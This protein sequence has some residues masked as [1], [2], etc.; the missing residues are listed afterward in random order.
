MDDPIALAALLRHFDRA[1]LIDLGAAP[2]AVDALLASGD[3]VPA[4]PG[5]LGYQLRE[6][7][8]AAALEQLRAGSGEAEIELHTRIFD[9]FLRRIQANDDAEAACLYHLDRLFFLLNPRGAWDTIARHTAAVRAAGPRQPQHHYQ[10]ALYEGLLALRS[11]RYDAALAILQPLVQQQDLPGQLRVRVHNSIGQVYWFQA[12][13]DRALAHYQQVHDLARA[14]GLLYYQ[15]VALLNMSQ[16]YSDLDD[17]QRA[18]E[19]LRQSLPIF[20][21][22]RDDLRAAHVHYEIGKNATLLGAWRLAQDHLGEAGRLY[23]RLGIED[24]TLDLAWIEGLLYHLT[25]D[26]TRSEAAY[27]RALTAPESIR[28]VYP[29][30]E[31]D[32]WLYLGFLYQVQARWDEAHAAY[33]QAAARAHQTGRELSLALIHY[34]R[35]NVYER[36]GRTEDALSAYSA[37]I[38]GIEALRGATETEEV[39]IGLLGTAQQVY[40]SM[41]LLLLRQGRWEDAFHYVERARSRAFLDMLARRDPELSAR[42]DAPVATL[43]EV[44]AALPEGALLLEYFT[45]GVLPRGEHL[46]NRIPEANARLR[47]HLALPPQTWIF[48]VTRE[49]LEVQRAPLDPNTLRPQPGDPGPGRRLLRERLLTTLYERLVAPAGHLLPGRDLLYLVPHGPLHYVPFM[50]LRAPSGAPLLEAGGPAIALAPS[51][52]VL[53][54]C[55]A[56]PARGAGLSLALGYDD[57]GLAALRYAEAE[58]G[59]IARLT[60]GAAWTGAAPK[61]QRLV[62]EGVR[63][64]RLHIAGHAIY[65]PHD[66]LGSEVRLGRG[67]SLTARAIIGGLRLSAELVT[68]SACTSGL[69]HVVPGDELLGLQRAFLFAGAPAVVCTLWEAADLVA[70]L[71]MDRFYRAVLSGAAPAAALRDA[72]VAVRGMTGRDLAETLERWRR[73]DPALSAALGELPAVPP[74]HLETRLYA[75]PYYWAPFM[76]IGRPD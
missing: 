14:A 24:R 32:V 58:A 9:Y 51:A 57:E 5:G 56:R 70:L 44:Q 25:G 65:H 63:L 6:E 64:R 38:A 41:V 15:G 74:E 59:H 2:E 47:E 33:E 54:M 31:M 16:V 23:H 62:E 28:S 55:L 76:L 49:G 20:Q 36:Q 26:E 1:L 13:Y 18:L 72:Q 50:A 17:P 73:E 21:A 61:S 22:L 3:A 34:R 10:L 37:A 27:R 19:L 45:T 7:R 35:G 48:A 39:K 40:E 4:E 67:D 12:R 66:P 30:V 11:Q 71:V 60:G 69:S 46:V 68:L 8:A 43:A 29:A 53:L 52:T 75:D 42:L